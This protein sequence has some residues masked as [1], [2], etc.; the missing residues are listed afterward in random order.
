MPD[1]YLLCFDL[2]LKYIGV[3]TGQTVSNSAGPLTTLSATTGK[4]DWSA[5]HE[6]FA[7]WKPVYVLI[8]LPLNMDDTESDMSQAARKFARSLEARYGCKAT[9]VDERLSSVEA[10]DRDDTFYQHSG[11]RHAMSAVVIAETWLN[12]RR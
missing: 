2:G 1:G 4:P 5:L 6:I 11:D 8:G 12:Q 3:A 9:L 7:T 10:D